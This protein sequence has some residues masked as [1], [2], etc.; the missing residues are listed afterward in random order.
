M[1]S[2]P[3]C[4]LLAVALLGGACA[5]PLTT[6]GFD[7]ANPAAK[8]YAMERAARTGD[9]SELPK[10]VAELDSDDPAVRLVAI[11]TLEE[12]TGESFKDTASA[13]AWFEQNEKEFGFRW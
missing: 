13:K 9:T 8:L 6:G 11:E 1:R 5:T 10:I 4:A 12:L 7:A 3:T 2:A